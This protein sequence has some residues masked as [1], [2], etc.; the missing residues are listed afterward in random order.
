MAKVKI[1][2][3][4]IKNKWKF[5]TFILLP[6][7]VFLIFLYLFEFRVTGKIYFAGALS[8][9]EAANKAIEWIKSY[10]KSRGFEVNVTLIDSKDLGNGIYQFTVKLSS[11]QGT[12]E[13][14]YYV[15]MDGK[16]FFPQ[17]IQTEVKPEAPQQT[18]AAQAIPKSDKPIVK[19]FI[20]SYCPFGLQMVKAILPVVELLKDKADFQLHWVSYAM[21]GEKEL[22]ENLRQYCIQ[23]EYGLKIWDYMKC[24]VSDGNYSRCLSELNFD[25]KRIESCM[26]Q[27]NQTYKIVYPDFSVEKEENEKYGVRGSPTLIINDQEVS[28]RRSPEDL[29][30]AICSAFNVQ[31][32][33]CKKTLS[34]E[35]ASPGFGFGTSSSS[36]GSCS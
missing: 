26:Q 20:M 34:S 4:E 32:E 30:N 15:S 36:A 25:V 29:K 27:I 6:I 7:T 8:P 19:L 10:F 2:I 11:S 21:H 22:I 23:K 18:R 28:V 16:L 1:K 31:P 12:F 9:N 33:E 13:E 3:P 17:G 24:F 14:T 35:Q 5:S